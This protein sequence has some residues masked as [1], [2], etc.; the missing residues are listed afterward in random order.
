MEGW[1]HF[2][3]ERTR[4]LRLLRQTPGVLLLSGDVHYAEILDATPRVA[5]EVTSSGLTHV[6][7]KHVYGPLCKPLLQHFAAHRRASRNEEKGYY[8]GL[9]FGSLTIDW[10]SESVKVSVHDALTGEVM[11]STGSLAIVGRTPSPTMSDDELEEI[12][13]CMDGHLNPLAVA[14]I[15]GVALLF[16][17]WRLK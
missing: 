14:A 4:L 6:C 2:P 7:T 5:T 3:A 9:N 15:A 10:E 8:I 1:C 11:L 13:T 17:V 12:P 16:L